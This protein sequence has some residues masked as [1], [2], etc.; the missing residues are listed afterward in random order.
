MSFIAICMSYHNDEIDTL[1]GAHSDLQ[2]ATLMARSC[3]LELLPVT[4]EQPVTPQRL[5]DTITTAMQQ[6]RVVLYFSGHG[7]QG[8]LVLSNGVKVAVLWLYKVIRSL[9]TTHHEII[10]INDACHGSSWGLPMIIHDNKWRFRKGKFKLAPC[11]IVAMAS[12]TPDTVSMSH[13]NGSEFS[14]NYFQVWK[15]KRYTK[16]SQLAEALGTKAYYSMPHDDIFSW[17]L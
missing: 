14:R 6:H 16:F 12:S 3:H 11:K 15:D 17:W 5:V 13:S 7:E 4:D 1:P 2:M 8:M 9:C 10:I